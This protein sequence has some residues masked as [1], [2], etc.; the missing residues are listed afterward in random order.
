MVF[1][2]PLGIQTESAAQQQGEEWRAAMEHSRRVL[3]SQEAAMEEYLRRQRKEAERHIR[4]S[5]LPA[6]KHSHGLLSM[7]ATP[8]GSRRSTGGGGIGGGGI[9]GGDLLEEGFNL[10]LSRG[11]SL[12]RQSP[13]RF[14]L[15]GGLL[16]LLLLLLQLNKNYYTFKLA[17]C[18][19]A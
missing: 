12:E 5:P 16:L 14:A 15:Q 17:V 8:T 18:P 4:N 9:G 6:R 11:G 1:V 7:P 2:L 19:S 3:S 10:R 13:S